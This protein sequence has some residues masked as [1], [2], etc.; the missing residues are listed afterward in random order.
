MAECKGAILIKLCRVKLYPLCRLWW[1]GMNVQLQLS[2][3]TTPS[4]FTEWQMSFLGPHH[5]WVQKVQTSL[6]FS[7]RC[8]GIPI[9]SQVEPPR[10]LHSQNDMSFLVPHHLPKIFVQKAET[11]HLSDSNEPPRTITYHTKA[12]GLPSQAFHF[13]FPQPQNNKYPLGILHFRSNDPDKRGFTTVCW[14]N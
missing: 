9:T 13:G 6:I 14:R 11:N 8:W 3:T 5:L 4:T 12:L 1:Q 2:R 10:H 7:M